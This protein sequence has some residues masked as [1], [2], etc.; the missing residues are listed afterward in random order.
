M[1]YV[2]RDASGTISALY[3]N[4]QPGLADETLLDDNP[5]L[6]EFQKVISGHREID[7]YKA[8]FDNHLDAVAKERQYDNR[9]SIATYA[10]STNQ[11]WSAEAQAF[12][13][14]RDA[15]LIYMF[16]QLAAVQAGEIEPPT[17]AEFIAGIESIVWPN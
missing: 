8:A 1:A 2:Q 16:E 3:R 12:I 10:S 13:V 17:V 7:E 4:A 14:W 6:L 5:E 11:A 9:V 15:A